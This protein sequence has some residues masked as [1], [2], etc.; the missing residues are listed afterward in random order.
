MLVCT[1]RFFFDM[2]NFFFYKFIFN[3]KFVWGHFCFIVIMTAAE[4]QKKL[5]REGMICSKGPELQSNLRAAART[6]CSHMVALC[7]SYRAAPILIHFSVPLECE[8]NDRNII[9]K[10]ENTHAWQLFLAATSALCGLSQNVTDW[11]RN[12]TWV[13]ILRSL[14]PKTSMSYEFLLF[15]QSE[16]KRLAPGER[17]L[18]LSFCADYCMKGGEQTE[19][20]Q[21]MWVFLIHSAR[22]NEI[23]LV[24][25]AH[26]HSIAWHRQIWQTLKQ[27]T[28]DVCIHVGEEVVTHLH[29]V[30]K[31]LTFC[32]PGEQKHSLSFWL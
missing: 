24:T 3:L 17:Y 5:E 2:F 29:S 25:A 27:N 31:F 18:I 1:V 9:L 13:W 26:M 12:F 11:T 6:L 22:S 32:L 10:R 16:K 14:C 20:K 23:S 15:H 19:E 30:S 28:L 7:K 8:C 4:R 21:R